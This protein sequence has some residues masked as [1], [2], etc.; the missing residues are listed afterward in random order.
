[1]FFIFDLIQ[2]IYFF[3][4]GIETR[5]TFPKALTLEEEQALVAAYIK[6]D[7]QAKD[8]LA[9]HN[10]RLVA[11]IVKK[12][13]NVADTEDLISIGSIGLIKA[14]STYA[15]DKSARLATYASRCIENEVLMFIRSTKRQRTEVSLQEPVGMD[16]EGNEI[17]LLD[18]VAGDGAEVGER[19]DKEMNA[20]RLRQKIGKALG[21]REQLIILLRYGLENGQPL[22]QREVAKM[23][24]ISRSYVSRIEKKALE[25]LRREYH[26]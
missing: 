5:K 12:Y 24:D 3:F 2:K 14:I 15:P 13:S 25:K 17:S 9:E 11:H 4:A 21:K 8:K 18:I 22:T 26:D 7:L 19:V 16:R 10:L 23:L 1:M 20:R 6:G